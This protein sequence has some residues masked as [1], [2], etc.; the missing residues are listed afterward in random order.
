MISQEYEDTETKY[1]VLAANLI[2]VTIFESA[3]SEEE[4]LSILEIY[5]TLAIEANG[6]SIKE[7][8]V[9]FLFNKSEKS[10]H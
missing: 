2:N 6:Y 4:A 5:K 8:I 7:P 1:V 9:G 3:S 10:C